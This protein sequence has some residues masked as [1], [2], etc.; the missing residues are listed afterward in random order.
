MVKKRN[1]YTFDSTALK[2]LN[3]LYSN[4]P[5]FMKR[6]D[7]NSKTEKINFDAVFEEL[8]SRKYIKREQDLEQETLNN[9]DV[10]LPYGNLDDGTRFQVCQKGLQFR[11]ELLRIEREERQITFNKG[12]VLITAFLAFGV[13]FNMG[14]K[15]F[16]LKFPNDLNMQLYLNLFGFV[17]LMVGLT[18]MYMQLR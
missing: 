15:L 2:I 6:V 16:A 11:N 9:K 7:L 13:M 18:I 10:C 14:Y 4:R 1:P 8:Y 3:I 17:I 5:S 12:L